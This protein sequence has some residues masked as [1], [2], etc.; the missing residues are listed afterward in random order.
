MRDGGSG[1]ASCAGPVATGSLV[2]TSNVGAA[3]TFTVNAGDAANNVTSQ[4]VAYSVAYGVCLLYD[5]AKAHR[6]GSTI[7]IKIQLCDINGANRSSVATTVTAT[8][9]V[10]L[11]TNASGVLE[12]SGSANQDLDFRYD[13]TVGGGGYMFNLKLGVRTRYYALTFRA[14]N[15]STVHAVQF[16]VK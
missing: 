3:G 15:D 10:L 5:P 2:D 1:I 6:S 14:T 12:D 4:S 16:Q 7:P 8:G 11:S 13:S 9:V